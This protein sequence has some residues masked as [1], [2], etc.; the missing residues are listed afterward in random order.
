MA[1]EAGW[2]TFDPTPTAPDRY[3]GSSLRDRLAGM[4]TTCSFSVQLGSGLRRIAPPGAVRHT[5]PG[6]MV[7]RRSRASRPGPLSVDLRAVVNRPETLSHWARPSTGWR[8]WSPGTVALPAGTD[9]QAALTVLQQ[10]RRERAAQASGVRFYQKV[11]A[12]LARRGLR[13][14]RPRPREFAARIEQSRPSSRRSVFPADRAIL[15]RPVGGADRA[16]AA[17][18]SA[19]RSLSAWVTAGMHHPPHHGASQDYRPLTVGPGAAAYGHGR[20]AIA[21]G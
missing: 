15:R 5:R 17:S 10:R 2:R 9:R 1:A 20:W 7:G 18:G 13:V 3:S 12:A 4:L 8:C 21:P 6:W 11:A 14:V 16:N 19:N